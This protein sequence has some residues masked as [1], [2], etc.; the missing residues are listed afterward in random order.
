MLVVL[1]LVLV[2]AALHWP[3]DGPLAANPPTLW[4]NG[5]IFASGAVGD[6]VASSVFVGE[7]VGHCMYSLHM[8]ALHAVD[9]ACPVRAACM[10]NMFPLSEPAGIAVTALIDAW[11]RQLQ[12]DTS[13]IHLSADFS[14]PT[15]MLPHSRSA[16]TCRC[17]SHSTATVLRDIRYCQHK[18]L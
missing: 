18:R 12:S 5:Q 17:N 4:G 14:S 10:D 6:D 9:S 13:R 7:K 2:R 11:P 15:C 1:P 16:L 3:C 8:G